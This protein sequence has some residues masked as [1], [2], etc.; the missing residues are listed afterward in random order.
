MNK[1][2]VKCVGFINHYNSRWHDFQRERDELFECNSMQ[3]SPAESSLQP[4][5]TRIPS[6]TA[7][8][9]HRSSSRCT[10]QNPDIKSSETH[11]FQH[12]A[13][14]FNWEATD[15]VDFESFVATN[16][17]VFTMKYAQILLVHSGDSVVVLS[18]LLQH[19]VNTRL[20]QQAEFF[21]L[22][23]NAAHLIWA[24]YCRNSWG[25]HS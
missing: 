21:C 8:H 12:S 1:N 22:Q 14:E 25:L 16:T 17:A 4:E 9:A 24:D 3:D 15:D 11:F 7:F 20:K 19:S 23:R 18:Q 2:R 6:K 13:Q 10:V 5:S